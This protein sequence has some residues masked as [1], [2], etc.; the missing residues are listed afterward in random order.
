MPEI[1][2]YKECTNDEVSINKWAK[3]GWRLRC[4]I[5]SHD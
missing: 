4:L 5:Y 1:Y 2:E 3:Q